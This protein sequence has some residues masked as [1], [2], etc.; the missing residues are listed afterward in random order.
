LI[1]RFPGQHFCAMHEEGLEMPSDYK[2]AVFIPHD[3]GGVW[4]LL[5][6]RAMKTANIDVD[7]NKAI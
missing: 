2:S 7:L 5:I 6:A 3:T 1:R 4:K